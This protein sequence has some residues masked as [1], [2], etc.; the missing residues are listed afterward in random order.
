MSWEEKNVV[1][2]RMKFVMAANG[3]WR[4]MAALCRHFGISR[5]TGYKWLKRYEAEGVP[6][7]DDQDRSPHH[8]GRKTSQEMEDLLLGARKRHKTWG[9]RKIRAW[10]ERRQPE[11]ELPAAS[12][13][14]SVLKRNGMVEERRL[15]RKHEAE[16]GP[17]RGVEQP[18]DA[19]NADYKG[20]FR[21]RNG[22]ECYPLT[23]TDAKSR[24]LICCIA[25]NGIRWEE[26]WEGFEKGFRKYGLPRKIHTDNGSP[27]AS[28]GLA[29]LSR[30]AVRFLKLG[31]ELDRSRPGHPEDNGR[32]ERFHWTL[33]RETALPP[34][35]TL[36]GQQRKFNTFQDVYNNERPHEALGNKT[37]AEIY[38]CSPRPYPRKLLSPEYPGHF[39]VRPV[40][41]GGIVKWKGRCVY[42]TD[43]LET[44][45]VGFQEVDDGV[46]RVYYG[47]M[48]LGIV[49]ETAG[50]DARK[51]RKVLP[52]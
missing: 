26:A 23:I 34:A 41:H 48:Q 16:G 6:G 40:H 27:F 30:L 2:E 11:L 17:L 3:D 45:P 4:N 42:V 31:I 43:S 13:I 50:P 32:H 49:D 12:T 18:N 38:R 5:K 14:G 37:P 35:W 46:F 20:Q 39:E 8:H 7:L 52:M 28:N 22:E 25:Y 21:V 24:F 19:W 9:P 36:R 1:E 47:S 10:L 33:K 15:R 44:E 29:G 51:A